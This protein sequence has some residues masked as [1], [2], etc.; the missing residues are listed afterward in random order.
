MNK[1][2]N[3]GSPVS[4][5]SFWQQPNWLSRLLSPAVHKGSLLL[6]QG[7]IDHVVTP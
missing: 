3:K 1:Y 2:Q 7:L 6:P 5:I 4:H